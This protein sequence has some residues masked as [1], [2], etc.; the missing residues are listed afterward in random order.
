M[1]PEENIRTRILNAQAGTTLRQN[2]SPPQAHAPAVQAFERRLDQ[3]QQEGE[4]DGWTRR[5]DRDDQ[6]NAVART[7]TFHVGA[8]S[9]TVPARTAVT[10]IRQRFGSARA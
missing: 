5:T 9:K 4:L 2:V 8:A 3:L 10:L 6:G 1:I 7:Y